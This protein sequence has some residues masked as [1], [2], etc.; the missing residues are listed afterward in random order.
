MGRAKSLRQLS[1]ANGIVQ[2]QT[3]CPGW[4]RG[5]TTPIRFKV[6]LAN[7]SLLMAYAVTNYGRA[8]R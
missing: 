2:F 1:D 7:R 3:I 5:R 4:Y 6:H 8:K